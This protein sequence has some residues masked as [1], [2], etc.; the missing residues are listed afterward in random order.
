MPRPSVLAEFMRAHTAHTMSESLRIAIE[1]A[2]GEI[3]KDMLADEEFRR[4]LR[5]QV[6]QIAQQLLADLARPQPERRRPEPAETE[7][8]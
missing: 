3:A 5:A 8:R 6:R 2:A 7:A 4:A 1:Q